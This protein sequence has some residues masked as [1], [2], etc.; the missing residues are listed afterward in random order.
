[1]EWM[2]EHNGRVGEA[3]IALGMMKASELLEE[4]RLQ[5][6]ERL[7]QIAAWSEGE[8]RLARD[9]AEIIT[10]A[11]DAFDVVDVVLRSC[12]R[13]ADEATVAQFVTSRSDEA[14]TSTADF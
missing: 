4:L 7:V 5:A 6:H 2:Q 13:D 14:I 9:E 11:V 12:M 1:Q 10:L 8:A 3:V